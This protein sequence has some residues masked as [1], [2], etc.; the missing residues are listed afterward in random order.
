[1]QLDISKYL[2]ERQKREKAQEHFKN[3]IKNNHKCGSCLWATWQSNEKVV[4][5]FS[6][7]MKNKL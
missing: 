2:T 4:C 7:C 3:D 1:M 5:P 6:N